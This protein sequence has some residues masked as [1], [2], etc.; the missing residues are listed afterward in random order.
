MSTP[1]VP[2]PAGFTRSKSFERGIDL[3][4]GTPAAPNWQRVRRMFGFSPSPNPIKHDAQTYDDQGAPNESVDAWG[5]GCQ[6]STHLYFN[7]TTGEYLPEIEALMARTRPEA[8]GDLAEIEYRTYH[9]PQSGTP[10]PNDALQGVATVAIS[11]TNTAPDGSIE[12]IQWTLAG[13]RPAASITNPFPGWAAGA[14]KITSITTDDGET[15]GTGEMVTITGTDL[16][17]ATA[18]TFDDIDAVD[19]TVLSATTIVAA[20]PSDGAGETQVA[21][22]TAVGTSDDFPLTRA[23]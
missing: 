11:R 14:P 13:V 20:L 2:L 5:H 16:L 7:P 21:V 8:I 3:N 9:K 23:A 15:P 22:T 18:V 12:T 10:N 19:F 6:F 4:L 1:L 17:G